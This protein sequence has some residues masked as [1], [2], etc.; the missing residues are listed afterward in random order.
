[1]CILLLTFFAHAALLPMRAQTLCSTLGSLPPDV[2]INGPVLA[3]SLPSSSYLQQNIRINGSLIVDTPVEF[4]LCNI[5][6][7]S[8]AEIAVLT[9]QDLLIVR[10]QLFACS[11][12][13]EGIK[14][15]GVSTLRL[16]N[17]HVE[18][19]EYAV[20]SDDP[21]VLI[22]G[23]TKFNRNYVG[24]R[25]FNAA[26]GYSGL[27]FG[28]FSSNL[29]TCTSG[30]NQSYSGQFVSGS[31]SFTGLLLDQC[32]AFVGGA[33]LSVNTFSNMHYGIY[34]TRS[35]VIV[36]GCVFEDMVEGG[37][38]APG[39][40]GVLA[41]DGTLKVIGT[42]IPF[43][44]VY[45]GGSSFTNCNFSGI[46]AYGANLQVRN[47]G[48]KGGQEIAIMSN[49]NLYAEEVEI[50]LNEV[51]IE[52]SGSTIGIY[53]ERSL[54]SGFSAHNKIYDNK[55]YIKGSRGG[56]WGAFVDATFPATDYMEIEDNLINVTST[57]SGLFP[58]WVEGG[59]ANRFR[60][61][62]NTIEFSSVN[63]EPRRWGITML[64]ASGIEHE[65]SFNR[66]FGSGTHNPG[67]CAIHLEQ[68][69]NVTLCANQVN[70]T[71]W[72]LH[73]AGDNAPCGVISNTIMAHETGVFI[74]PASFGSPLTPRIG[75]QLRRGNTWSLTPGDYTDKAARCFNGVD[76]AHSII[77]TELPPP[78]LVHPPI[79]L[80]EP[81]QGWFMFDPGPSNSGCGGSIKRFSDTEE[82]LLSGAW[83]EGGVSADAF[84]EVEY[85]LLKKLWEDAGLREEASGAQEY[86]DG[87]DGSKL[88]QLSFVASLIKTG[89]LPP[90]SLQQQ[91]DNL[92]EERRSIMEELAALEIG[93]EGGESPD[94]EFVVA[95]QA[96]FSALA[97]LSEQEV[98]LKGEIDAFRAAA[99]GEAAALNNSISPSNSFEA[100]QIALNSYAIKRVLG[101]ANAADEAEMRHIALDV[102][103][104]EG[105]GVPQR[106]RRWLTLEEKM[107]L[108]S[109]SETG[110][111]EEEAYLPIVG[112][113][114]EAA[115]TWRVAP[116]PAGDELTIFLPEGTSGGLR[117]SDALGQT[118]FTRIINGEDSISTDSSNWPAG[119][120]YIRLEKPDGQIWVQ[121]VIIKH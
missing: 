80:I 72:G 63:N 65:I 19:A 100:H 24:I 83:P 5:Q 17:S 37:N 20:S 114:P 7:G 47:A 48:F 26:G 58:V 86:F 57:A 49:G 92:R 96:L 59:N 109:D 41:L 62:K 33:L 15:L 104:E 112:G 68:S 87:H 32:A 64:E 46:L 38:N 30:L 77:K 55:I 110:W 31:T 56:H 53:L 36:Q 3:S 6:F 10:S 16:L 103:V 94:P 50:S 116:N 120:Y 81:Q 76:P 4:D 60:V 67:H 95:K 115:V 54:A 34:A 108:R 52:G 106:A 121:K 101:A 99:L 45:L 90:A 23:G 93:H 70:H 79:N 11:L 1:L 9:G 73:F 98:L 118:I 71:R 119:L 75:E 88:S 51:E 13:W 27:N 111:D 21:S 107:G 29:F 105:A 18:D 12:T 66:I 97:T 117:I 43:L 91:I 40:V 39:G 113:N 28:F 89:M 85:G 84:W 82:S 22:V 74:T 8:G 25:N 2:V 35:D 78:S 69:K 61:L 14:L 42:Y 44:D 102:S